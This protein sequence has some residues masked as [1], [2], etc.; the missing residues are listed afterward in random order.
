MRPILPSPVV[1]PRGTLASISG[2]ILEFIDESIH[3]GHLWNR[4][5]SEH[6][7]LTYDDFIDAL[8]LLYSISAIE[9][10]SPSN[11]ITRVNHAT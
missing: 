2:L 1:A 5:H 9:Y 8:T 3:A 7:E 4:V 6:S 11:S 10:D